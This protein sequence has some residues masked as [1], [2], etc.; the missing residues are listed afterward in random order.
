MIKSF[1]HKGLRKLFEEDQRK[2]VPADMV[3]S[4][5]I[6]L[7]ALDTATQVGDLQRPSFKL[8]PLQGELEGF[9]AITVRANWRIVFRFKDGEVTDVDFLDYH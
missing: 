8:H 5:R 3:D 7:A 2:G 1:K 6:R 4:L 9:L